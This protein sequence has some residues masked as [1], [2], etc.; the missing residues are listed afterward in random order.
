[1][2]F[3]C[4]PF[5]LSLPLFATPINWTEKEE[6]SVEKQTLALADTLQT[7]TLI[8]GRTGL[9]TTRVATVISKDGHILAPFLASIDGRKAPYLLY[10][11]DG[12]R[13][14]LS[15]IAERPKR[16][17]AL[18]K[19]KE[20]DSTFTASRISELTNHTV[21]IPT[22]SPIASLGE[23]PGMFIDHLEFTPPEEATAIRLDSVNHL[24]GTPVFDL[25]GSLIAT[26]LKARNSN[27]PAISISQLLREFTSLDEILPDL[28]ESSLPQLPKAPEV[29][30]EEREELTSSPITDAR[31]SFLQDTYPSPLPC[32]HIFN[33]DTQSTHSVIG[34]I[35]R[36]DGMILTK[37]SELGPDLRVS[38]AGEDY[39]GIILATDEASDLALVGVEAT[40][41]PTVT[42]SDA[43]PTPGSIL[44]SPIL[45]QG[46]SEEMLAEPACN[47]GIFTQILK[48]KTPTVH[49]TSQVTS[50]GITTEQR[51]N[52]LVIAA[53]K[54]DSPASESGLSLGDLIESIDGQEITRRSELT[55]LLDSHRVGDKV[56]LLVKN[57][58]GSQ[59]IEITL[60]SPL[61]I[62]PATGIQAPAIAIVPSVRRSPFPDVIAHTMPLNA[63]D[64]GS[65]IF[66]RQGRALGLNIAAVSATRSLALRP[67]D[68]RKV[69][70]KL[71]AETR[72]F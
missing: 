5:I 1:M 57:S 48:A 21:V 38:I 11:A 64:C 53:L 54:K 16:H 45:L 49:S 9:T 14:P 33:E 35:V 26:T 63:W 52:G 66:D 30:E 28:S 44:I 43:P 19:L 72:A 70:E 24:P 65:P 32:A 56:T 47:T 6:N 71:L 7:Q 41:L 50:L 31:N 22:C 36:Q 58:S 2:K 18:L 40:G 51:E 55:T 15:T 61:L 27:I 12:S 17:L 13:I 37:A 59:E 23:I 42:W 4:I 8:I 20:N 10:K 39:P 25:S 69:L 46:T 62:P 60:I 68:V 34:T 67:A 3:L 29:S